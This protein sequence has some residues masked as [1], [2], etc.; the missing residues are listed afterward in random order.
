MEGSPEKEKKVKPPRPLT[1]LQKE[2]LAELYECKGEPMEL[3]LGFV[4]RHKVASDMEKKGLAKRLGNGRWAITK[5]GQQ[6][7]ELS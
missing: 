5:K 4:S 3:G 7:H 1:K 6:V 2:L